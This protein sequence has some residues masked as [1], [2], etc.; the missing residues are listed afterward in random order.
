[1]ALEFGMTPRPNGYS[2]MVIQ[3]AIQ[4]VINYYCQSQYFSEFTMTKW[5][6]G[7]SPAKF[8]YMYIYI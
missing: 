3:E 5:L 8:M 2:L 1:M 6:V 4:E 7:G